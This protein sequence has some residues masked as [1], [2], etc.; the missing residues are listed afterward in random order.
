MLNYYRRVLSSPRL[1]AVWPVQ[2]FSPS[3]GFWLDVG[4]ANPKH[5]HQLERGGKS[6]AS[7]AWPLDVKVIRYTNG[8]L[9]TD[10]AVADLREAAA[11]ETAS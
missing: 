8:R 5:Q 1:R 7:A 9:R 4:E 3:L 6:M 10:F 11:Q 2:V